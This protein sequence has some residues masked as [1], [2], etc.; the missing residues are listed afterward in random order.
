MSKTLIQP[1]GGQLVYCPLNDSQTKTAL[2]IASSLPQLTLSHR[3]LADLECI[4]TGVYSPLD[5]FV[6]E[7]DYY[8]I[9][10]EMRLS[11]GLAWSIPI[12]LQV[13][14]EAAPQYKLDA[15]MALLHP[16][17]EILAVMTVTS[18]FK[19]DQDLEAQQ[20]YRTTE[21]ASGSE[22]LQSGRKCL[23]RRPH[24]ACSSHFAAELFKLSPDSH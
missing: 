16:N 22:S 10:N 18:K 14:E 6:N 5:G 19:P 12:T 15:D 2:E 7:Q 17:G 21:G 1:H 24:Q 20:V 9:V 3:N 4:A 23:S 8:T 13:S 11:N